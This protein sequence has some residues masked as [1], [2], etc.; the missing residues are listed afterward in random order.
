MY[1]AIDRLCLSL[2]PGAI[3]RRF[4][5]MTINYVCGKFIFCCV[6]LQKGGMRVCLKL[7]YAHLENPPAFARDVSNIGHYGV[8]NLQL[9]ITNMAQLEAATP[10]IRQSL[11]GQLASVR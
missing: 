10:L 6:E 1:R 5:A 3:E 4:V 7:K 11:D 2:K 9:A 8:G